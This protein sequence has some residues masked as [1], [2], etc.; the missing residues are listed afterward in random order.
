MF[1]KMFKTILPNDKLNTTWD[2]R[3]KHLAIGIVLVG[4]NVTI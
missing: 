4:Q 2:I 3:V 1:R